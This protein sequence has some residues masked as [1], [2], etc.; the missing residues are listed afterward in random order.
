MAKSSVKKVQS[1]VGRADVLGGHGS[2]D[3]PPMSKVGW[4]ER[5][6]LPHLLEIGTMAQTHAVRDETLH[7]YDD[8]SVPE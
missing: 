4:E 5:F 1:P 3:G 8:E 7:S 6:T 2:A